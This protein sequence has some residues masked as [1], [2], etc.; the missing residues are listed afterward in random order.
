MNIDRHSG[1]ELKIV[2]LYDEIVGFAIT[3]FEE[4]C[5]EYNARIWAV[6]STSRKLTPFLPH[7]GVSNITFLKQG[8]VDLCT[9]VRATNPD[10]VCVSGWRNAEYLRVARSVAGVIPVACVFD[11]KWTGSF[12]QRLLTTWPFRQF[13]RRHFDKVIVPGPH[14]FCYARLLGYEAKDILLNVLTSD[15]DTFD[16]IYST[17]KETGLDEYPHAFLFVGRFSPEKGCDLLV[18]AFND[19]CRLRTHDWR[20]TLVG[21]GNVSGTEQNPRITVKEFMAKHEVCQ[22]MGGAGVFCMPSHREQ[23]GVAI[24][25]AATSGLPLLLSD[26]CGSAPVFLVPGYNG[27]LFRATSRESLLEALAKCLDTADRD[28]RKMSARS[29]SLAH[30]VTPKIAA[31]SVVAAIT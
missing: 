25:E 5:R 15:T 20:L 12:K 17:T 10:L 9:F 4:I 27:W 28:L 8:D 18:Q 11:N 23:W 22:E 16:A 24:H 29:H 2:F 7:S 31:A 13:I 1:E 6:G 19:L 30:R 21:N 3:L 14:Q 26:A